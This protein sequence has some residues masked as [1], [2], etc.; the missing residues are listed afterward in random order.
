[1]AWGVYSRAVA[2]AAACSCC[3]VLSSMSTVSKCL[4]RP[5]TSCPQTAPSGYKRQ[6]WGQTQPV[7]NQAISHGLT[8]RDQQSTA[9]YA[10]SKSRRSTLDPRSHAGRSHLGVG[11]Q[12]VGCMHREAVQARAAQCQAPVPTPSILDPMQIAKLLTPRH[13]TLH[14]QS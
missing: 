7:W 1:M 14:P 6:V 4:A 10:S 5:A 13:K 2:R 12:G 8:I 3:R 11:Q 9:N